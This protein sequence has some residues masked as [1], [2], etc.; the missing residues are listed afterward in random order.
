[1]HQHAGGGNSIDVL[2][3][4]FKV[5]NLADGWVGDDVANGGGAGGKLQCFANSQ[6]TELNV[7]LA[8]DGPEGVIG[9]T[10]DSFVGI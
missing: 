4:D 2:A 10:D 8:V 5:I 9:S 7:V 6:A 3:V 1:M